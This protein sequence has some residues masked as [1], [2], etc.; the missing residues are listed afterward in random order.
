M[1]DSIYHMMFCNTAFDVKMSGFRH[2]CEV[3]MVLMKV[4][5]KYCQNGE[6]Q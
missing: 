2:I 5:S 3:V 6:K 4:I 1:L